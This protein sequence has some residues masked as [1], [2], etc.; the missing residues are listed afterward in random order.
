MIVGVGGGVMCGVGD[1]VMVGVGDG[2]M[3]SVGDGVIV[4]V[5]GVRSAA[6]VD[7]FLFL[8]SGEIGGSGG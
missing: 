2:V 5:G 8:V 7:S 6:N 3:V 1:G 4:S